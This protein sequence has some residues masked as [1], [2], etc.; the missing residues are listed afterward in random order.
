MEDFDKVIV[1]YK[2][3][4]QFLIEFNRMSFFK[5][6]VVIKQL[7]EQIKALEKQEKGVDDN[8]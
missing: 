1:G 4:Y 2:Q 7:E 6:N 8:G 5:R 3:L